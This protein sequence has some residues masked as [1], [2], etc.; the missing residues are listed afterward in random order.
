MSRGLTM[1]NLSAKKKKKKKRKGKKKKKK[2]LGVFNCQYNHGIIISEY[3][4]RVIV[5]KPPPIPSRVFVPQTIML[6][7]IAAMTQHDQPMYHQ[8]ALSMRGDTTG[9][10][11]MG[12]GEREREN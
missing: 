3:V 6:S 8:K 1:C 2:E 5:P 10:V 9:T 11:S 12:L 4:H 7:L